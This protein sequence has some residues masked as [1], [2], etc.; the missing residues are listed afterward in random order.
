MR[1]KYDAKTFCGI[2]PAKCLLHD[3]Y[4][5][6][7]AKMSICKIRVRFICVTL[8]EVEKRKERDGLRLRKETPPAS[9]ARGDG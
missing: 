1:F 7:N 3:D 5:L 9:L 2:D 4:T 6:S 8:R